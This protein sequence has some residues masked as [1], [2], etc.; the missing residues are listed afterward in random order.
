MLDERSAQLPLWSDSDTSEGWHVRESRRARR[1]T[2][3]V[4][5]GGRVEVV[6]P[7]RTSR[8]MVDRFVERHRSWIE[9]KRAEARRNAVPEEPFPP[10]TIALAGARES[11]RVHAG[12]GRGRP[13]VNIAGPGL[14][15]LQGDLSS[16]RAVQHALRGWLVKRAAEVFA[17]LLDETA[18]TMDLSYRRLAVRRQRT[19]WGSCSIRGTISLNCCLLFQRPEVLRYLLVHELAHLKHMNHSAR[20]WD[21]VAQ[22]CPDCRP[23]DR[24]LLDGWRRVPSWVFRD[25]REPA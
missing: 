4:F 11:W 18:R 14:L 25:L 2:V 13:R 8:A 24:E 12:S 22:Y 17:P 19:R 23:L 6:V 7:A 3:R 1:L 9:K 16:T 20:F 10:Q 5:H 15:Q 21:L